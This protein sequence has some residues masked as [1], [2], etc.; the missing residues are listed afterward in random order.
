MTYVK[1]MLGSFAPAG[2][3]HLT[4]G[5]SITMLLIAIVLTAPAFIEAISKM[6]V[7]E[8]RRLKAERG[9]ILR[10]RKGSKKSQ[11]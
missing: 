6:K 1:R 7:S 9:T 4:F 3:G 8:T 10:S 11:A 5:T 2:F